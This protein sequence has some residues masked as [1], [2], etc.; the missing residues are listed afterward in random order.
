MQEGRF[1]FV[2]RQFMQETGFTKGELV[3]MRPS[4]LVFEDDRELVRENA[5][6]MLKGR[7]SEAFEHRSVA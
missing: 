4:S 1:C 2:N 5:I 6:A 7:R 3:Q